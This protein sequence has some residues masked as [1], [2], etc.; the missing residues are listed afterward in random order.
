MLK[1]N[2]VYPTLLIN[3]FLLF[4]LTIFAQ[5]TEADIYTYIDTYHLIA[6]KKMQ[7]YKIPASITLAQGI[8][9]SACGT[10]RLATKGNNH[11]GIKCHTNWNGDTVRIDDDEL[12][13]CFRKYAS[14]E[15]SY[16]DH[17]HFLT[18]RSRY[19]ELFK[20]DILDY[21]AWAHGL[22]AAGYATNP[23]YALRLISLI[24][25]FNIA[26]WDT[27]FVQHGIVINEKRESDTQKKPPKLILKD[28][29]IAIK[30]KDIELKPEKIEVSK[31]VPSTMLLF[32]ATPNEYPQSESP[33]TELAVYEN[34]KVQF[35]IAKRGDSFKS[36]AK[37]VQRKEKALRL[38]NDAP[39]N[40]EP[41]ENQVIYIEL[42]NKKY[43]TT[44]VVKQG[45]TL[46]YI[47][48][49]YAVQLDYILKYN[50]L[51]ES[52]ILQI[53]DKIKLSY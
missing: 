22:K 20:L 25:R 19:K 48:Q 50:N 13:E 9:E 44:H 24:E 36:I 10:S 15:E 28:E 33:W 17:S 35:I 12:Q 45:E 23:E 41:V 21:K 16:N 39:L 26:Q 8:F 51:N 42:K 38:F 49:K 14:V 43:A 31:T 3:S 32:T 37:A 52:S 6:Q 1:K 2:F 5:Y 34:N 27:A 29:K 46:R 18:S 40:S 4:T 11:F 7:E 30:S 53:G 47:A